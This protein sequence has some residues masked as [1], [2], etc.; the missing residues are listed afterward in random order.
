VSETGEAMMTH[1]IPIVWGL[2]VGCSLSVGHVM[3]Y[4]QDAVSTINQTPFWACPNVMEV[5][6]ISISLSLSLFLYRCLGQ[7]T[8]ALWPNC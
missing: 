5:R 3:R 7:S 1:K 2:A 4:G 8:F 6:V